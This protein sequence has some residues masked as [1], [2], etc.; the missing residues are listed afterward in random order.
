MTL[1]V[2]IAE[3]DSEKKGAYS[4]RYNIFCEELCYLDKG[5]FPDKLEVDKYDSLD[6]TF[7]F[8]AMGNEK[9]IGTSRLIKENEKVGMPIENFYD[10]SKF[11][12]PGIVFAENSRSIVLPEY[13]RTKVIFDIWSAVTQFALKNGI[14]HYCTTCH[15][16]DVKMY[17][18][19]GFKIISNEIICAHYND[20]PMVAL[21]LE[22]KNMLE[23]FKTSFLFKREYI[24]I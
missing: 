8:I 10:L 11:R 14:T 18:K 2:K 12:K 21:V 3:T 24:K 22:I 19:L 17:N 13:R 16:K 23:P 15:P 7:T 5:L 6:E 9:V 1:E 20:N 4:L